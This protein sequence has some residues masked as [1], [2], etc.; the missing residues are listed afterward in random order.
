MYGETRDVVECFFH[1]LSALPLPK[2]FTTE[3]STVEASLFVKYISLTSSVQQ[4][5][6]R[7]SSGYF[8]ERK[9]RQLTAANFSYFH[10]ELLN[11]GVTYLA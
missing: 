5:R 9:Q 1:F 4:Q 3:Q 11:A 2:C 10:L 6:E 7:L 8:G